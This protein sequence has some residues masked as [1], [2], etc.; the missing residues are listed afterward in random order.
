MESVPVILVVDDDEA[1]RTLVAIVLSEEGYDVRQAEHGAAALRLVEQETP[2]LILLDMQMPVM[3]G[4]EFA[5][6]YRARPG[7][8]APIVVCTAATDAQERARQIGAD[9]FLGKPFGIA[10]LRAIVTRL[11]GPAPSQP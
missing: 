2:A 3:D 9:D 10:P 6:A 8:H 7:P 4:W 1:I 5:A 11:V